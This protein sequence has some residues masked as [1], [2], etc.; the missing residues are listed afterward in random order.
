MSAITTMTHE[1]IELIKNTI[2]KGATNDELS[3]FITQCQRTGLDPLSRQIYNIERGGK[4]TV[5]ISIDGAR[6]IAERSG[7]YSGQLGPFWCGADAEWVDVWLKKE[8][9]AAAKVGVLRNDF[10]E[11]LFA[12]ANFDAYNAKN[13]MW[14]KMPALM[15]AKCAEMLALRRAF[16]QELSGLYSAE[17]MEQ[18]T[19]QHVPLPVPKA[20]IKPD[21]LLD[22]TNKEQSTIVGQVLTKL[23]IP[24]NK[25]ISARKELEQALHGKC[26]ANEE[27]ITCLVKEFFNV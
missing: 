2:C 25:V 18:A 17:E 8:A 6:L 11:P 1:Q 10:R 26:S 7:K 15:I 16:P 3:L 13:Q 9:P 27:S 19:V 24:A 12:V 22:M 23:R 21:D 14:Q 5:Q 4:R 20:E